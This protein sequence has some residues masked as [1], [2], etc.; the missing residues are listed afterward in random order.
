[1]TDKYEPAEF[2]VVGRAQDIILGLKELEEMDNRLDPDTFHQDTPL[3][4]FEE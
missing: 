2:A 4:V 3:A 1:M